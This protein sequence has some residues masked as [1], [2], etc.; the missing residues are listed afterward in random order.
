MI[1]LAGNSNKPLAEKIAVIL[2]VGLSGC[3]VSTFSDG[4]TK[5]EI[6]ESIRGKDV[7][8]IQSTCYPANNHLM[9]LLVMLDAVKR[10]SAK[11][12]TA[13]IPYFGYARQDRKPSPRAPIT[14]KLVADLITIAGA[15]R[16]LA[17]DLHANQIQGFFDIP[18]D[19]LYAM[20]VMLDYIR[21]KQY[22]KLCIVS[23]DA[24][25]V[26]R[27]RAYAKPLG[28]DL[29]IADKRRESPNHSEIMHIVGDV[30]DKTC[31][32][33]DDIVDTAGTLVGAANALTG[34]DD[35]ENRKIWAASASACCTHPV[36][37]GPAIQ[38]LYK[39]PIVELVVT[40]TIPLTEEASCCQKIKIVSTASILATAIRCVHDEKSVSDL[41]I[42]KC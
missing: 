21:K 19:N 29:A 3:E 18:V 34:K 9:E 26:E 22:E 12:V 36:L 16:V 28:A 10:A 15:D 31:L 30:K 20:S 37:S 11:R 32:L 13:V 33:V 42:A 4:E 27:A 25:G 23:P 8:I 7:F 35:K 40:D 38:R 5:V 41:F 17:M 14:A 24:G 2:G 1:L 39:S 6:H